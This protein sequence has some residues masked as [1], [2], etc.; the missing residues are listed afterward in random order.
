[1][2]TNASHTPGPWKAHWNGLWKITT[3]A[4]WLVAH[5]SPPK[6]AHGVFEPAN[7]E[8]NARL[9]A[10]APDLLAALQA[11]VSNQDMA[12]GEEPRRLI[13]EARAAIVKAK[14]E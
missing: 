10:A 9:I 14:G 4:G 6:R 3:K 11:I 2:K 1:M 13:A 12:D 8:A 5:L 7:V